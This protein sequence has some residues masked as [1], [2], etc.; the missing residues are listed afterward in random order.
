M[1]NYESN[2]YINK[3]Y[4]YGIQSVC[5]YYSKIPRTLISFFIWYNLGSQDVRLEWADAFMTSVTKA[6]AVVYVSGKKK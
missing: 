1:L 4:E 6:S 5:T 2:W 3:V